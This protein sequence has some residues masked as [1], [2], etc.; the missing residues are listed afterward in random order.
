MRGRLNAAAATGE[1]QLD[2]QVHNGI[3]GLQ[4]VSAAGIILLEIRMHNGTT[5]ACTRYASS[6]FAQRRSPCQSALE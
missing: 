5:S 4:G 3:H 2:R 6:F 1:Y